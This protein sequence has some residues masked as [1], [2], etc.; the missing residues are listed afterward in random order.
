M[1]RTVVVGS[2]NMDLVV[3]AEHMPAPGETVRGHDFQAIPGGK[4]ANQAAALAL[5]GQQV[6]MVGRVGQDAFGPDLVANL[7]R[8]GVDTRHVV[9]TSDMATGNAMIIVDASGQNSIVIAPGANGRVSPADVEA[10]DDLLGQADFLVV[11]LEIPLE[12]VA[13][14]VE[15]ASHH[16]LRIVLNPAPAATVPPEVLRRVDFL[17]PNETEAASLTGQ[18]VEDLGSAQ[19]AAHLLR[20][21]G[22]GTVIVTL[23]GQ[24]SFTLSGEEAFHTPA[25]QVPVVD[26]TAAGDA[27]IGGLVAGLG[28]SMA[29][30]EAVRFASCAGALA[31]TR[32]GAQTSLPSAQE[33]EGLYLKL[34]KT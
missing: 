14:A 29:L 30:R 15:R 1:S 26:T 24:G 9:V 17:V 21:A 4:G 20:Q 32:F 33:A 34:F 22:A 10:C 25:P 18:P 6:A 2:L 23:G 5:L 13:Y 19:R 7:A 3:K 12:T 28:R 16:G 27:F 8:K 31:V 11:Q